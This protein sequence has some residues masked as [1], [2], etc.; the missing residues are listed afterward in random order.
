MILTFYG[1]YSH[2]TRPF[3]NENQLVIFI[4]QARNSLSKVKPSQKSFSLGVY[5]NDIS[6]YI[7]NCFWQSYKGRQ[8]LCVSRAGSGEALVW[9][10]LSQ[11]GQSH[12][13]LL[14]GRLWLYAK[15]CLKDEKL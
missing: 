15:F 11:L 2:W 8:C 9:W 5:L 4:L 12:R 10:L 6:G 7:G 13:H 1:P 3:G 14:Y